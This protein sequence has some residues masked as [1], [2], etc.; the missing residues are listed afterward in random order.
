MNFFL[1]VFVLI[2]VL[3]YRNNHKAILSSDSV[4]YK[5]YKYP[6]DFLMYINETRSNIRRTTIIRESSLIS[7]L[8]ALLFSNK[9]MRIVPVSIKRN[10][11]V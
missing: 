8:S 6:S 5:R 4:N 11:Y 10:I 7:P 2:R 3:C 9:K 1:L